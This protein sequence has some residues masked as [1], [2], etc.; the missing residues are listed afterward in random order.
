MRA[1]SIASRWRRLGI[2]DVTSACC[3]WRIEPRDAL[4]FAW[5]AKWATFSSARE[6]LQRHRTERHQR[7]ADMPNAALFGAWAQPG[8]SASAP[9][10]SPS[11]GSG[12]LGGVAAR[13]RV[14][15][16]KALVTAAMRQPQWSSSASPLLRRCTRTA[17]AAPLHYHCYA[18]WRGGKR[19]AAGA[20]ASSARRLAGRMRVLAWR[21]GGA[22]LGVNKRRRLL[23][24]LASARS[25]MRM[26]S[27]SAAQ[28]ARRQWRSGG[29]R[30]ARQARTAAAAGGRGRRTARTARY[31]TWRL[32][33]PA[34]MWGTA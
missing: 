30:R 17:L 16:D 4:C 7:R 9:H 31:R 29:G 6:R 26:N 8:R 10:T 3:A 11:Y 18:A 12:D 14:G 22:G 24:G 5:R 21:R 27:A 15:R 34:G 33:Q 28:A 32:C 1:L 23:A 19:R 25:K 2:R 20:G 13:H